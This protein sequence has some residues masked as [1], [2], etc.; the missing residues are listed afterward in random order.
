MELGDN[1]L[2]D[3]CSCLSGNEAARKLAAN[4]ILVSDDAKYAL[5]QTKYSTMPP[6]LIQTDAPINA[7]IEFRVYAIVD[8]EECTITTLSALGA[9]GQCYNYAATQFNILINKMVDNEQHSE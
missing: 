2:T 8:D 1:I 7:S 5:V 3:Y 4:G 9:P 6:T